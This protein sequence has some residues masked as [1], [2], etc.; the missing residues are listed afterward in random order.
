MRIKN[1]AGR[2]IETEA[3]GGKYKPFNG[4]K[5]YNSNPKLTNLSDALIKCGLR[6]GLT[7]SFHHQLRNGDNV[8]NIVLKKIQD[9]K[10]KN[11]RLAQTAMFNVH[12]PVINFIS[13]GTV[14][15]IEGSINGIVG[16]Y[17]SK[18][19]LPYPVVLRSHGGRWAA[20]KSD[21]LHID[22]AIIAASTSDVKGNCTGIIGKT[23]FGPIVYSQIDALKADRVIIVTD[24]I[25]EYPCSFQEITEGFVDFVVKVDCI[26]SP[27]DIVSGTTKI[28]SNP[29]KQGIAY[30]CIEL[31]D[32]AGI[33]KNGMT[34]QSGAGDLSSCDKISWRNI[35]GER[36]NCRFC[37]WGNY[38][39]SY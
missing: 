21:E 4:A 7:I 30:R 39:I 3:T 29:L 36:I 28:T 25:V 19:P 23:A 8:I 11:I 15:R 5:K 34:F 22:I 13:E 26:G 14:N 1:A 31:M 24:N 12:E 6:D 18:N 27:E 20:I 2:I 38:K 16:N 10:I 37:Y 17:I 9:L 33:I 32:A 35:R